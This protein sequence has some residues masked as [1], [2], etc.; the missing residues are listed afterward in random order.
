MSRQPVSVGGRG[1]AAEVKTELLSRLGL[2]AEATEQ[3]IEAAHNGL[4]EFLELA[5]SDVKS[6]A[7]SQTADVDEAFAF[8]SG[9]EQ[10]LV[11]AAGAPVAA[12]P[13]QAATPPPVV[14]VAPSSPAAANPLRKKL[15]MAGVPVL[16]AGVVAGV[17]FMGKSDV[18]GIDGTP[19]G[20]ETAAASSS[21]PKTVPVD[22]VK[23]AALTKKV[24]ANPKDKASLQALGDMYFAAADYKNASVWERKILK[25]D[26]KNKVALISLGAAQFNVG[27][28]A[29]AK[30]AWLVAAKLYPNEAEVH[31]DLGFMYMSQTPPDTKNMQAEWKKV[32]DI[33]P[34]SQLAKTVGAHIKAPAPAA[35]AAPS[36]K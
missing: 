25:V 3:E 14:P 20:K 1:D 16:I 31:Y 22:K 32:V 23:V 33:D 24:T 11:Q 34:N 35:S 29:E 18:P 9:P 17:F 5:P 12:A 36:A 26:P 4:V 7:A 30:K 13:V 6:W 21:A 15:L 27:N 19:T 2:G 8:L 28:S 10:D